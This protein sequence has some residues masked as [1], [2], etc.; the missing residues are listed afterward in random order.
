[1]PRPK[2]HQRP[3]E[4]AQRRADRGGAV[5]ARLE[6]PWPPREANPNWR[7][8]WWPKYEAIKAYRQA[9]MVEARSWMVNNDWRRLRPPVVADLVIC[10]P[11]R[12]NRDEDNFLA[13]LKAAWDGIVDSG[14][15]QTDT[16]DALR[17][18]T[19]QWGV[20]KPPHI[21]V[22]LREEA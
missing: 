19:R 9:A 1:M 14:L 15:L 21:V 13:S 2:P 18:G 12:R 8:H 10:A 22:T 3:Q 11:D 7:G 6:L 5:V 20:G 16:K 17:I 4:A